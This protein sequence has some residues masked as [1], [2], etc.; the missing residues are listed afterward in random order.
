MEGADSNHPYLEDYYTPVPKIYPPN[1]TER[2]LQQ[3]ANKL[4]GIETPK[5]NGI[6]NN[7]VEKPVNIRPVFL[8]DCD[9]LDSPYYQPTQP[10]SE[11]ASFDDNFDCYSNDVIRSDIL[12]YRPG[13]QDNSNIPNYK[14]PFEIYRARYT[15]WTEDAD[16]AIREEPTKS[17]IDIEVDNFDTMKKANY[18]G[19]IHD[20]R[21]LPSREDEIPYYKELKSIRRYKLFSNNTNQPSYSKFTNPCLKAADELVSKVGANRVAILS[22]LITL[23]CVA[24]FAMKY[25][26]SNKYATVST[27][28]KVFTVFANISG[29]LNICILMCALIANGNSTALGSLFFSNRMLILSLILFNAA[30]IVDT[31]C[32]KLRR[33][34]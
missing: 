19:W 24:L 10:N 25:M 9:S 3:T 31:I 8:K 5:C 30:F 27:K 15:Q 34:Y 33:K 14:S 23:I 20:D 28:Q 16:A 11:P 2:L 1:Y 7:L 17:N 13:N 26:K 29:A 21:L 32:S 22:I 12:L 6:E 18:D 4:A